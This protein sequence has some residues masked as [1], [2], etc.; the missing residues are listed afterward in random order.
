M[1]ADL[2][3][4]IKSVLA[5]TDIVTVIQSAVSLKKAGHNYQGLCPF[6]HEKTPSFSVNPSKQ[7]F[8]CFGCHAS[9][10][11][12]NFIMRHENLSFMEALEKCATAV[13]MTVPSQTQN[14][15]N[16]D[17]QIYQILR[18][19]VLS[20]RSDLQ[21]NNDILQYLKDRGIKEHA[22]RKYHLGYCGPQYQQWFK[23]SVQ[24]HRDLLTGCGV[25]VT[26]KTGQPATKFYQ[27]LMF[28][29]QDSRGKIIGFGGR[30]LNDQPPKYLN[31]PESDLFKKRYV[32]YGLYQFRAL[33]VDH[34]FVVEGYMDVLALHSHGIPNAV[35]CLGT[36]FTVHHWHLIKRF[37]KSVTFC[38]DA[39]RAG[40]AAAWK[41][42]LAFMPVID[43]SIAVRF[44]FLPD[45]HDPDSYLQSKGRESFE[46]AAESAISWVDFFMKTLA[47]THTLNTVDGRAAY[48]QTA[49]SHI[50]TM[51]NDA[52][53][54]TMSQAVHDAAG[55]EAKEIST[56][57]TSRTQNNDRI[58]QYARVIIAQL[59]K[60]TTTELT[61]ELPFDVHGSAPLVEVINH[62]HNVLKT[63]PT[64]TGEALRAELQGTQIYPQISTILSQSTQD[65][66][67]S[68][69]R[70]A[71]LSLRLE[72]IEQLIQKH[73][74]PT[75]SMTDQDERKLLQSLILQKQAIHQQRRNMQ[76]DTEIQK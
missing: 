37:V 23:K 73:I 8:Y 70:F 35:A 57:S 43:P 46:E 42:V 25:A 64:M 71:C 74:H 45:Q 38:F 9:G 32:L 16:I 76:T 7:F 53:K 59:A 1:T 5:Q 12:L 61:E 26:G 66:H 56:P 49:R 15:P 27:R 68:R 31:S 75:T 51:E 34:V 29:I 17:K 22:Q 10:D 3:A 21:S 30:S 40:R 63:T 33:K 72:L 39:D 65:F 69:H 18:D 2:S 20:C 67:P 47:E 24:T 14:T 6:H 19:M 54:E 60:K 44:L 11:A 50:E 36:A 48:L 13:G 41:S 62:W 55:L 52:L 28:P 4:F 58:G